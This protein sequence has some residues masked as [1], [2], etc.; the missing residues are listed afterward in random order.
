MP[1]F[2]AALRQRLIRRGVD[3]TLHFSAIDEL[4]QHLEDQ[5]RALI[6]QGVTAI[7]A[8][9]SALHELD[10]DAALQ[11]ELQRAERVLPRDLCRGSLRIEQTRRLSQG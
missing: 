1:D 4:A 10:D 8:E 7:E 5:Y 6:S 9:Q 2:K 11:R 3:P